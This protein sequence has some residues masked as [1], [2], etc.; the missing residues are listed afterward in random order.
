MITFAIGVNGVPQTLDDEVYNNLRYGV[1]RDYG[2]IHLD[3]KEHYYYRRIYSGCV[4]AIDFITT[5]P[6]Y[7][8]TNLGVVGASQG[9]AL[10]IVAAALDSRVKALVA[11]HPAMCDLTGYLHGRAGG[12][13]HMFAAKNATLNNKPDKIETSRYYDVVE[14]C[15]GAESARILF[16]GL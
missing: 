1:L 8:G 12:W 3:D 16:M 11:F 5:L 13:P 2:F 7:D 9:G 10:S 15:Q 14:F 6:A 4:R